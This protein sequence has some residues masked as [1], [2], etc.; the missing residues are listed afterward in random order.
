MVNILSVLFM[1]NSQAGKK[2]HYNEQIPMEMVL[3]PV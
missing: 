2:L 1:I 3:G